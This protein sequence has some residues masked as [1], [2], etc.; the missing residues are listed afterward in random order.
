[1]TVLIPTKQSKENMSYNFEDVSGNFLL[2]NSYITFL[3]I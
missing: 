2:I 1:M 3:Q